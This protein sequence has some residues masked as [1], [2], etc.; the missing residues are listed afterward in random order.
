MN[1]MHLIT[2]KCTIEL[3]QTGPPRKNCKAEQDCSGAPG[4]SWDFSQN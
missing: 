3:V 2:Q 4:T 1:I